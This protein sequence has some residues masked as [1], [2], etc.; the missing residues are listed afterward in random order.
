ML[1]LNR[2]WQ[3]RVARRVKAGGDPADF[4]SHHWG[5]AATIGA[6]AGVTTMLSNAAGPLMTLYL[7]AL[8]FD[9]HQFIGTIAWYF[10]VLNVAKV[11]LM[12]DLGWITPESVATGA[13]VVPLIAVGALA[14]IFLFKRI[15]QEAFKLIV[16]LL[17]AVGAIKL[18]IG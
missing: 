3:L 7:L 18:I 9:K 15:G 1:L 4:V 11:P 6:A 17:A 12:V 8:R 2:G 16:E 13:V 14:G 5:F 10:L